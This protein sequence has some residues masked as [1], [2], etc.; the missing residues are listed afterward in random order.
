MLTNSWHYKKKGIDEVMY[1]EKFQDLSV[2]VVITAEEGL[3]R[4]GGSVVEIVTLLFVNSS[5]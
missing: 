5:H 1:E 4:E 3:T 2:R